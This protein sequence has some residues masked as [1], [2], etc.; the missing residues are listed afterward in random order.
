MSAIEHQLSDRKCIP[1]QAAQEL[2]LA[3]GEFWKCGKPQT[4]MA[5]RA[6]NYCLAT[7]HQKETIGKIGKI[8][9]DVIYSLQEARFYLWEG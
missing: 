3:Q 8:Y 6:A 5:A 4:A 2:D 9:E 7:N 1:Q